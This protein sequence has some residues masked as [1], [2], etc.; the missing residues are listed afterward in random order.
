MKTNLT[1]GLMLVFLAASVSPALAYS[2]RA[3]DRIMKQEKC[4]SG[5]FFH[6]TSMALKSKEALGLSEGQ[7][8]LIRS[9]HLDTQKNM[10][11]QQADVRIIELELLSKMHDDRQGLAAIQ[12]IIDRQY[13]AKKA[14]AKSRIEAKFK[15]MEILD[16]K[17]RETLKSLKKE[18]FNK[19]FGKHE[20]ARDERPKDTA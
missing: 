9:L 12:V 4:P 7:V 1:T 15:L 18:R 14:L 19:R 16:E 3:G 20:S 17:Q 6:E 2:Q 11:R 5:A 8:D 10:I 13:E